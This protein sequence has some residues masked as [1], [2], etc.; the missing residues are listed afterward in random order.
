M[1]SHS[2]LGCEISA[3]VRQ[4][5]GFTKVLVW[6]HCRGHKDGRSVSVSVT[7]QIMT[8][9]QKKDKRFL[10]FKSFP[11]KLFMKRNVIPVYKLDVSVTSHISHKLN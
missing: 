2:L 4:E 6:T 1:H 11:L 8:K 5:N 10:K 7:S 9:S 3:L